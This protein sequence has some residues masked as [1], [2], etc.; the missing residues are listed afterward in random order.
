MN[1]SMKDFERLDM[2][3]GRILNVERLV[4]MKKIMKAK[5]DLGDRTVDAIIGGAEYYQPEDPRDKLVAVVA[6]MDR[7]QLPA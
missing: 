7:G 5:I 1:V 6:N 4:G 3:V 2:R